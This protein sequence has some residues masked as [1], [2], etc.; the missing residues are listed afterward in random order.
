M[1]DDVE[2]VGVLPEPPLAAELLEEGELLPPPLL[3]HA[4]RATP[5][6]TASADVQL[7]LVNKFK[8][9][10]RVSAETTD[11]RCAT[12]R[13]SVQEPPRSRLLTETLGPLELTGP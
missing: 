5:A 12:V 9:S 10:P 6:V 8:G 4:A 1:N 11:E 2:M 3:L 7:I 13:S